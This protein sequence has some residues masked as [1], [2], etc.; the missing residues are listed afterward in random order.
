MF[1]ENQHKQAEHDKEADP[2]LINTV[3]AT[4][5][6]TLQATGAMSDGNR[7]REKEQQEPKTV[8]LIGMFFYILEKFWIVLVSA[9]VCASLMGLLAGNS[10][11]TYSATS[12]L[13]I[14]NPNS[15]GVNIADLQ[16]GTVL[17]LDYQE[18]FKTWE[19]HEMV[20]EGWSCPIHTSRCSLF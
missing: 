1:E 16:L 2:A 8:D 13:Y 3:T 11:T 4:V 15:S 10:V 5:L 18:V 19:V 7:P 17:T 14:V 9:V 20:I 6:A 12:K